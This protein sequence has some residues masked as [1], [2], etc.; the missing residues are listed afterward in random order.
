MSNLRICPINF[1]DAATLTESPAMVSTMPATN[2]QLTDRGKTARST[3]SATQT[4]KGTW[5]GEARIVNTFAMLRHNA[6]GGLVQVLL[7]PNSDW[8]GTPYDST[9]LTTGAAITS[10]S[11]DWGIAAS[12]PDSANDLLLDEAPYYLNFSNFTAKS[13]E[14]VLASC[15]RSYWD[16][17]RLWLG[18]YLEAPY[19]PN[20]GMSITPVTNDI[21]TRTKGGS[22]R[23]RAGEKWRDLRADMFYA[24][25]ATRA[26]WRDLVSYVQL[27]RPVLVNVFPGVGGR[28]ERDYILE[29]FMKEGA[30][31]TWSGPLFNE[32]VYTFTET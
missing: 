18:K 19:N 17:G 14:I 1:F 29:A 23:V 21:Q 28:Q 27:S 10:D 5:G 15:D 16:I 32:A 8:T 26:L 25:D 22:V 30:P 6:Q 9:A 24:T 12:A 11:H 7:Y 3:S 13:F 2:A 20:E 31:F 4:I